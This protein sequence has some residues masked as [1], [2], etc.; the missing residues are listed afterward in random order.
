MAKNHHIGNTL[1]VITIM[2]QLTE[3]MTRQVVI[4]LVLDNKLQEMKNLCYIIK[5]FVVAEE[6][7][8]YYTLL[9][10]YSSYFVLF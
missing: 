9:C 6:K 2:G 1:I 7:L 10:K 4:K 5:I 3:L 8:M